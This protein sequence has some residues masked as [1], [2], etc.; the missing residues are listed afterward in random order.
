MDS[1]TKDTLLNFHLPMLTLEL[2][3]MI[4]WHNSLFQRLLQEDSVLERNISEF[5]EELKPENIIKNNKIVPMT[6]NYKNKV[7]KVLGNLVRTNSKNEKEHY[8]LSLYFIDAT[9]YNML[10]TKHFEEEPD[11]GV[12]IIDNY[13]RICEC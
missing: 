1:V 11:I 12:V 3:G 10:L 7:Y 9:E 2:N 6:V 8:T 5:M 4:I 13:D